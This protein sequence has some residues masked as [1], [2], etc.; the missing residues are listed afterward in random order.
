M[1]ELEFAN[2]AKELM[3]YDSLT[4]E[5][6]YKRYILNYNWGKLPCLKKFFFISKIK[7]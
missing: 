7:L 6:R 3:D 4:G 2:N 5:F 1:S